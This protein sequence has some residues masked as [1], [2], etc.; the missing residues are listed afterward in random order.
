ML[1]LQQYLKCNNGCIQPLV[2]L[3]GSLPLIVLLISFT[4][5]IILNGQVFNKLQFIIIATLIIMI[6]VLVF[7]LLEWLCANNYGTI[8]W[9]LVGLPY[10]SALMGGLLCG[11]SNIL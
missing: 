3:I 2:Y 10:I 1:D 5:G 8:G 11:Y 4:I 9:V 6:I 7:K